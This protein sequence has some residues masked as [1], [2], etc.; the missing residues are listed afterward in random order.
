MKS[1][2]NPEPEVKTEVET[3]F[4]KHVV[5]QKRA[6]ETADSPMPGIGSPRTIPTG[7]RDVKRS[8]SPRSSRS[9]N[10][11]TRVPPSG[12]QRGWAPRSPPRGP[13][14]H[15]RSMVAPHQSPYPGSASTYQA[16]PRLRRGFQP[17]AT[18][19]FSGPPAAKQTGV[20]EHKS[21]A[22]LPTIPKYAP[23]PALVH[24][25]QEILKLQSQ[26]NHLATE[27]L[28]QVTGLRR[29]LQELEFATIDLH[30]AESRRRVADHQLVLANAGSLGID[31][32]EAVA[33]S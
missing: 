14:N 21:L 6:E 9:T 7:P 25:E 30:A 3:T 15:P 31:A 11:F 27:H 29:A 26:R 17:Q 10:D 1:P 16:G 18:S 23:P 24:V 8:P 20:E 28:Q 5:E 19:S 32:T 2:P 12:S 33:P 13:R 22:Y 4:A